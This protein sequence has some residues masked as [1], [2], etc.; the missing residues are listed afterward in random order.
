MPNKNPMVR[1]CI[2]VS[3]FLLAWHPAIGSDIVLPLPNGGSIKFKAVFLGIPPDLLSSREYVA[4]DRSQNNPT[5]PLVPVR[6][7]GAFLK[8]APSG[9]KDW[10]FYIAETEVTESQWGAL[11]GGSAPEKQDLPKTQVSF[12]EIQD[13]LNKWNLW[14]YQNALSSIP[15]NEG[16]LGYL[17]LPTEHEWE[18][19]A[20]GGSIVPPEVF[21]K[22]TPYSNIEVLGRN[23]WLF[24]SDA[25]SRQLKPVARSGG[26]NPLGLFDMF[27]N[28]S[29]LTSS[30]YSVEP[31]SGRIGGFV[32]KGG[33]VGTLPKEARSAMRTEFT[34]YSSQGPPNSGELVGFRPIIGSNIITSIAT[35]SGIATARN[36]ETENSRIPLAILGS[37]ME[38]NSGATS[39]ELEKTKERLKTLE[40]QIRDS[41]RNAEELEA[42]QTQLLLTKKSLETAQQLIEKKNREVAVR[43][44]RLASRYATQFKVR[45]DKLAI[46]PSGFSESDKEDFASLVQIWREERDH[47]WRSYLEELSILSDITQAY[48]KG[49]NSGNHVATALRNL[50]NEIPTDHSFA[51]QR[52]HLDVVE[53]MVSEFR[54]G[55]DIDQETVLDRLK[56]AERRHGKK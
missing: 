37:E 7:G 15:V 19:A 55:L 43:S 29:E 17:R 2:L 27:G 28:A 23:E 20:R 52:A 51:A 12:F 13:F 22:Q 8:D 46:D 26:S 1:L 16:S 50:R 3:G 6:I 4:G 32:V 24:G 39:E 41:S 25:S 11:M 5:E 48:E 14:L 9:Q 30:H 36:S 31:N 38:S 10:C 53:E 49:F 35:A 18:F 40:A 21:D 44:S 34:P 56:Q 33:D 47:S 42:I 54:N 45:T